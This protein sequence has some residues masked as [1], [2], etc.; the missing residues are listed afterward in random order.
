MPMSPMD[1]KVRLLERGVTLEKIRETVEGKK[2]TI[3]HIAYVVRGE[4]TSKR[5]QKT[6]AR[7]LGVSVLEAFG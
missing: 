3:G 1:R 2:P 7:L 5:I 4:R 6:I